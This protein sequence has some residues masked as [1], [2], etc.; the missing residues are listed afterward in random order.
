MTSQSPVRLFDGTIEN[1]VSRESGT[2]GFY[3]ATTLS[4]SGA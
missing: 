1:R 3:S 4:I 2:D